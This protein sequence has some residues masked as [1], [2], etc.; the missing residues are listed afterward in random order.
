MEQQ[1]V[2]TAVI[3]SV[4]SL[5]VVAVSSYLTSR[6]ERS[7]QQL[8]EMAAL[9]VKYVNPL[10]LYLTENH[11]RLGRIRDQIAQ[12]G[13][14]TSLLTIK[15]PKELSDKDP[16][17]YNGEGCFLVSSAY[18]TACLFAYL[19]KLRDDF[20]YLRLSEADDTE[21]LGNLLQVNLAFSGLG[22][23]YYATQPSMGEDL[24]DRAEN[25]LIS[26][27]E[28]CELLQDPSS[29]VWMDGLITFYLAAGRGSPEMRARLDRIL[30]SIANLIAFLDKAVG[31]G[32]S[33]GGRLRAEMA[34][35]KDE[36]PS[37]PHAYA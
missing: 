22:G 6:R 14:H 13:K 30:R 12:E 4:T 1:V 25:R 27:R 7:D 31:G 16:D 5:L 33:I 32:G 29:R 2:L 3:S 17:W 8:S 35:H 23:I 34:A 18:L 24:L 19:K 11:W 10:R 36:P 21:L 26:Y 37:L 20:P 15:D 28:F 9:S